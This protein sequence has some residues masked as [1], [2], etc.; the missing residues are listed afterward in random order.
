MEEPKTFK[1]VVQPL[2]LSG[3]WVV[4][5]TGASGGNIQCDDDE[6]GESTEIDYSET[7]MFTSVY[8]SLPAAVTGVFT[9]DNGQ[10]G[11]TW[12]MSPGADMTFG[13]DVALEINGAALFQKK[14]CA[15]K[16]N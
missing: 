7:A 2:D 5:S 16:Q 15:Y 4:Y 1:A 11:Y 12:T 6:E 13:E 3:D 9:A 8:T 10:T 14:V